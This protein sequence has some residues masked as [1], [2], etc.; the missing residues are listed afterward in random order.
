[1]AVI[2]WF[3]MLSYF[4]ETMMEI[5]NMPVG[6]A[7]LPQYIGMLYFQLFFYGIFVVT[8]PVIFIQNTIALIKGAKNEKQ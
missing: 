1:M 6:I 7:P 8:L 3:T 2:G 5:I 4:N